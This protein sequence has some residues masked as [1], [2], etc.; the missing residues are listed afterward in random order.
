MSLVT[1]AH[2]VDA[3]AFDIVSFVLER[4]LGRNS[5]FL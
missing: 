5:G 3:A 1:L 4:D 2:G